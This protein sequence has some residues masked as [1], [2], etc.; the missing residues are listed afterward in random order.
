M[1][2][3]LTSIA[4]KKQRRFTDSNQVIQDGEV[5]GRGK[6]K[7]EARARGEKR[8]EMKPMSQGGKRRLSPAYP[9]DLPIEEKS[10]GEKDSLFVGNDG[11]GFPG[12]RGMSAHS[13]LIRLLVASPHR[14][15][16]AP[17]WRGL[18]KTREEG[19]WLC[20][21]EASAGQPLLVQ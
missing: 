6:V 15:M 9:V 17:L 21:A 13:V 3:E 11:L 5:Q 1:H 4:W 18:L 16:G 10:S 2:F 19:G 8:E 20:T 12:K 7:K 14:R